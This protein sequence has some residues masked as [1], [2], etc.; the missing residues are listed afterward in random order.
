MLLSLLLRLVLSRFEIRSHFAQ[1]GSAFTLL[2]NRPPPGSAS[3]VLVARS[4]GRE[5]AEQAGPKG[6]EAEFG[7][8]LL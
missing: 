5:A 4:H 1:A 3:S 6:V 7:A 8:I 2:L